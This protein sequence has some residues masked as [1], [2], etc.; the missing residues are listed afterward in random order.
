MTYADMVAGDKAN[1]LKAK[2]VEAYR[3]ISP[4]DGLK[5]H[6]KTHAEVYSGGNLTEMNFELLLVGR[7]GKDINI[8]LASSTVNEGRI[9]TKDF[10]TLKIEAINSNSTEIL[11]T[12]DQIKK[13]RT[14][15]SSGQ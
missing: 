6:Y 5:L 1:A 3:S 11:A 15:L 14:L 8:P 7:D 10:G 4:E 2:A 12:E 13:L 9:E